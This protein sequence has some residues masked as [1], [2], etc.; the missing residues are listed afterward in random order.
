MNDKVN[1]SFVE[2]SIIEY[3]RRLP[4]KSFTH[5]YLFPNEPNFR[6]GD[7]SN[8]ALEKKDDLIIFRL[9]MD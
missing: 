1:E 3:E 4:F 2:E 9:E 5:K 8:L 7:S 6:N